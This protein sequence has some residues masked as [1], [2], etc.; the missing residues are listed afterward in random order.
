MCKQTY[1][2]VRLLDLQSLP[3]HEV[4]PLIVHMDDAVFWAIIN[5][6]AASK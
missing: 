2:N 5:W 1:G 3:F 4:L 6:L